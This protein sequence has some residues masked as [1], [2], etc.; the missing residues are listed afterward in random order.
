MENRVQTNTFFYVPTPHL[1]DQCPVTEGKADE[2]SANLHFLHEYRKACLLPFTET[3]LDDK[4]PNR[5]VE[6]ASFTMV[7]ADRDL[8]V[9][10][11]PHG[12]VSAC[13]SGTSGVN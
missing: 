8:T 1:A 2:V 11:K 5:E 4:V 13:L 9:T 6:P 12:G 10:G 3:W 7:R